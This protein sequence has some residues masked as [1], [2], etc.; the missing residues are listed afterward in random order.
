MD[1]PAAPSQEQIEAA[2]RK[3]LIG[4]GNELDV[5]QKYWWE[6]GRG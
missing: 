1:T 3:T 2:V 6:T 4:W 5:G